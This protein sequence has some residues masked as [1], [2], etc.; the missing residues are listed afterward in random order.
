MLINNANSNIYNSDGLRLIHQ[1]VLDKNFE[2]VKLLLN[3]ASE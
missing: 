1:V 2:L 3:S